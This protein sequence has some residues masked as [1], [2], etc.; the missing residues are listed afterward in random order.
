MPLTRIPPTPV[1]IGFFPE[2]RRSFAEHGS[3]A[4]QVKACGLRRW[5]S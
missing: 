4:R 1:D 3:G 2:L 5:W